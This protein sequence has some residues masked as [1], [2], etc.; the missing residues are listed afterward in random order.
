MSTSIRAHKGIRPTLG[1][2]V[3]VDPQSAVIGDVQMGDDCSVWP[4]AVIRGDMHRIRIGSRVSIQDNSTLHITHAGPFQPDGWP[5]TIG[6]DVTIGHNVCLH[7]C[8]IGNEVLIGIGSTVLDG[9][10]VEDQVV[11][12]AGT[13][14][15]PGKV[16]ESGYMYMG[17]PA[18]QIRPLKEKEKNFF[19]YTAGNYVKLKDEYIA[20][21]DYSS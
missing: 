14:V 16:L 11:I 5:L 21:S 13:L 6:S 3:Y 10:V 20:N 2:R 9:A 4:F 1:D 7:G 8:S 18:K 12:G 19:K 15:P 17:A